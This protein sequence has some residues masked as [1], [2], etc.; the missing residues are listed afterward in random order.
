MVNSGSRHGNFKHNC[1]TCQKPPGMQ[2]YILHHSEM[3]EIHASMSP[4]KRR[5]TV[6]P[7]VHVSDIEDL[8]AETFMQIYIGIKSFLQKY[9][10]KGF[11]MSFKTGDWMRHD[12]QHTHI[13][14]EDVYLDK[15]LSDYN[16]KIPPVQK[17]NPRPQFNTNWRD[18]TRI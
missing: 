4:T 9:N 11:E 5:L 13:L 15:I 18:R 10:V 17:H 3:F 2:K 7:N 12:H 1:Y 14:I 6:T 16:I 8:G